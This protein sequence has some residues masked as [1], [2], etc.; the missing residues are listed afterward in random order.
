MKILNG[1]VR[2]LS[3]KGGQIINRM[4]KYS[5]GDELGADELGLST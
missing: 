4:S 2:F 5:V 3:T 1:Y